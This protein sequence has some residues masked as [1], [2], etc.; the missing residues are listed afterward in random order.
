M[1]QSGL[2]VGSVVTHRFPVDDFRQAFEVVAG[3]RNAKKW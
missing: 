1:L 3:G 2:D